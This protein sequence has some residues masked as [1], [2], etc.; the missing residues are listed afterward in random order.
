MFP[1][2][3]GFPHSFQITP[4]NTWSAVCVRMSWCRRSQSITP[5]TAVPTGGSSPS[6]VCHTS[7]PSLRTPVT[8]ASPPAQLSKP[9]SWGW[10]PPVG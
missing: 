9:V 1:P 10:P 3:T 7:S 5:W 2:I 6:S 8:R 4:H